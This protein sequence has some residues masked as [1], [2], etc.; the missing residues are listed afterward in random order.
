MMKMSYVMSNESHF[1]Y[2]INCLNN[3]SE[4]NSIKIYKN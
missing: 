1:H 2:A 4:K 3:I